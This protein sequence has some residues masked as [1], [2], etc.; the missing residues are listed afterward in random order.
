MEPFAE[1]IHDNVHGIQ[2]N[3]YGGSM[4]V[5]LLNHNN[6][7]CSY[8]CHLFHNCEFIQR[9]PAF[10][11]HSCIIKCAMD[12][13]PCVAHWLA[14]KMV[15]DLIVTLVLADSSIVASTYINV[16]CSNIFL[17]VFMIQ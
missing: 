6:V 10:L 5:C 2:K 12:S 15:S 1:L 3:I 16:A 17:N 7:T 9:M 14:F 11:K 8:V 13:H 4:R